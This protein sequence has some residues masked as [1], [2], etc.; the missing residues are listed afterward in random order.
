MVRLSN[1]VYQLLP[2]RGY[3][4]QNITVLH[5]PFLVQQYTE[6]LINLAQ[7]E[8]A[9]R[10]TAGAMHCSKEVHPAEYVYRAIGATL[11]VMD[12][13]EVEAQYLLKYITTGIQA[14]SGTWTRQ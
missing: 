7:L 14:T 10:I 4:F 11:R 8:L 9:S 13:D 12:P 5:T 6:R 2:D 3:A 1:Q